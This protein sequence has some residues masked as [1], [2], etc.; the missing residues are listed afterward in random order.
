MAVAE[1]LSVAA[2][3]SAAFGRPGLAGT[4]APASKQGIGTALSVA[5]PVWFTLAQ[6]VVTEVYYPRV[7]VPNTRDLQLLTLLPGGE[8]VE[9]RRDMDATVARPDADALFY[10]VTT[11]DRR[12]RFRIEKRI[13]TDP[14]RPSLAMRVRFRPGAGLAGAAGAAPP[15]GSA[16]AARLFVLLAPHVFGQSSGNS[17]R[18]LT[19]PDGRTL[20][21]AC[22]HTTWLCL[23]ASHPVARASCG[24]AG[25][26]DGWTDLH[27]HGDMRWAFT[28]ATDG[29]VAVMAELAPGFADRALTLALGFGTSIEAACDHA[30]ATADAPFRSM[31]MRYRSGWQRWC[32]GLVDLGGQSGDGGRLYRLSAMTLKA[33]EDKENPGAHIASLAVPWGEGSGDSNAGGYHLVWPRDLYHSATGRLAAG[34]KEGAVDALRYLFR[35]QRADGAWP[36][37]FWVFG[38]PYWRG[39]QLDELAFP[40]LLAWQC[41][42][43]GALPFNPYPTLVVP[44]AHAVARL[45]PVTQ[46][47]R[48]EENGGYSPST[49]ASAIAGLVCAAEMAADNDD[50]F[51][52]QYFLEVADAWTASLEDWTYTTAGNIPPSFTE[53]YER[54]VDPAHVGG[55]RGAVTRVANQPGQLALPASSIIDGGFLELV[56]YGVR[57]PNDPHVLRSLAAYDAACRVETPLGPCWHRYNHDG[58]GQKA[59]GGPYDGSGVGRAWPLLTGERAHYELAAGGD[60]A[61]LRAALERF[62]GVAGMLPEQIWDSA[63][64]PER[65]MHIGGP[66]GSAAPLCWAHAEYIKLLRSLHDGS[67]FDCPAPVRQRYATGVPAGAPVIWKFNNK[68]RQRPASRPLRV[69]VYAPGAMHWS[70]DEWAT[71]HH[72]PMQPR[73]HGVWTFAFPR[74]AVNV[75]FTFYWH[76]EQRWEGRD[77]QVVTAE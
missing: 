37:N 33:H 70:D 61:A 76:D 74:E 13:I 75:R 17:A 8:V 55:L 26:S 15:D 46:E 21:V 71:I 29:N 58:Y 16:A 49:L 59:D 56:R 18:V 65:G 1:P 24:F 36:Q 54:V 41:R 25:V 4:W 44:A 53:Y 35:T 77:F 72:D 32:R 63:D 7:D 11:A 3:P 69:E 28:E 51:A 23:A 39:L 42:R 47:E 5:S 12:G 27:A 45:G 31:E 66:T 22:R 9:E 20:L 62:A 73:G 34:D 64:I 48:W 38:E 50:P 40:I 68:V 30:V 10:Q 14:D 6:G 19:R 2:P 43:A 60:A 57:R 67:V 52:R